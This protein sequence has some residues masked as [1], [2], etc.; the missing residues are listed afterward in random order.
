MPVVVTLCGL[1]ALVLGTWRSYAVAREA[2]GPL[3]HDG[4]PTRTAI[5]AA[6]PLHARFRIRL[7]LRRVTI[8]VGWL[9]VALYGLFLVSAA[10]VAP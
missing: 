9:L 6:R 2:L 5:E 4:D 7:F 3:A 1:V 8:A 10:S